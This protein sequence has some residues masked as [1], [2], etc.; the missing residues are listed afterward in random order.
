MECTMGVRTEDWIGLE[1]AAEH[2]YANR[3]A[4]A[5]SPSGVGIPL[6]QAVG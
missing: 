4:L 6:H 1:K 3:F 2:Y 5:R